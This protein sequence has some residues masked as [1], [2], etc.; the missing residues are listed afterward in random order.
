MDY[1]S[2]HINNMAYTLA[3]EKLFGIEPPPRGQYLRIALAELQR[4]ASHLVWLGTHALDIG[5]MTIFFYAFRE[6]EKVMDLNEMISGVRMMPSWIVPGG[7]RGD[8]PEGYF[9]RVKQFVDEF[10]Y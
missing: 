9:Q 4:I 6:R 5:A 1:L 3:V 10:P 7:L 2:A 8:A